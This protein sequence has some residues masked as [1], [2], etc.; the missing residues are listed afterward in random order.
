MF[1]IS[2]LIVIMC[3]YNGLAVVDYLQCIENANYN[4]GDLVQKQ[5]AM[6]PGN[7]VGRRRCAS[8]TDAITEWRS[9]RLCAE[10]LRKFAYIRA[11]P[12]SRMN[13]KNKR[14][15]GRASAG[16]SPSAGW[17]QKRPRSA[18]FPLSRRDTIALRA[19]LE[20]NWREPGD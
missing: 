18:D 6:H 1:S 17:W 19:G 2:K 12:P 16:C 4:S 11:A 10:P 7:S 3:L 9:G 20:N 15:R 8:I 14:E 13:A 5:T